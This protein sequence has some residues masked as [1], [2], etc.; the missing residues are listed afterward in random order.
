LVNNEPERILK[1]AIVIKTRYY[2]GNCLAEL[3]KSAKNLSGRVG[4][5]V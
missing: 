3:R 1:E 2:A 4:D 5:L